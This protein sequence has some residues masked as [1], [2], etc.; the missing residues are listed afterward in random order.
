MT[1]INGEDLPNPFGHVG[2]TFHG[3]PARTWQWWQIAV[4]AVQA[5]EA[6]NLSEQEKQQRRNVK[7]P[8]ILVKTCENQDKI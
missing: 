4:A 3:R 8:K 5:D 1:R 6:H 7:M 2:S